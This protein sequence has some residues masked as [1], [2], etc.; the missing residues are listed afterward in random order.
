M[1]RYEQIEQQRELLNQ[2]QQEIKTLVFDAVSKKYPRLGIYR[3]GND[4]LGEVKN[5]SRKEFEAQVVEE[6]YPELV[7]QFAQINR[8]KEDVEAVVL[9]STSEAKLVARLTEVL[10]KYGGD[11][12]EIL[13][14]IPE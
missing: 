3:Y 12:P 13:D 10:R 11:I 9:L 14:Y 7:P 1:T 5:F 2:E 6:L 8:A 4:F